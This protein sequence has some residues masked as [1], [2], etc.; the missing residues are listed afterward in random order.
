MGDQEN[1]PPNEEEDTYAANVHHVLQPKYDPYFNSNTKIIQDLLDDEKW[2]YRQPAYI[3]PFN[4][5][6]IKMR[7][8]LFCWLREIVLHRCI[9]LEVLASAGQYVDRFVAFGTTTSA[10]YQ[11]VGAAAVFIAS[12]IKEVAPLSSADIVAY[13]AHSITHKA[14]IDA[15]VSL[16]NS[17]DWD[18]SIVTPLEFFKPLIALLPYDA[19]TKEEINLEA[20]KVF[21][22]IFPC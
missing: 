12:K 17:F 1:K 7:R 18:L 13:T 14:L 2:Y 20:T 3:S 5:N 15:E 16:G 11:L 21:L 22:K 4:E 19:E 9:D 8:E 10:T 6:G